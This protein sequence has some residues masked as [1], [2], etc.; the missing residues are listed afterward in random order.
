MR[1]L[2]T[3]GNG[4]LGSRV[5][6]QLLSTNAAVMVLS[7][8]STSLID[9]L[10]HIEF[11]HQTGSYVEHK[12]SIE[13]FAP[14]H[15]LHFAWEGGNRYEDVNSPLQ[16]S[17]NI[18]QGIELLTLVTKLPSRPQFLGIGSFSE[19]GTLRTKAREDQPDNPIS[20][21]G[22]AK[23]TFKTISQ[24][25]CA[26]AGLK[27]AW[28]RPCYVYGPND[29]STRLFPKVIRSLQSNL[30]V[31]LDS[32]NT[33][34]DYLHV[35]DFAQA[36]LQI[37][38]TNSTGILNVC[39]GEEYCLRTLLMFLKDKICSSG[40]I[41]FAEQKDRVLTSTYICGDNSRLRMIG[42]VPQISIYD[43]L[44]RLTEDST[45]MTIELKRDPLV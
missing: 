34:I 14:T 22:M 9:I 30:T 13:T 23:S 6:R 26:D 4:F 41:Q 25:M 36:V 20:F 12:Q 11:H 33:I 35:D 42:W 19:Y 18:P 39:S 43:G 5:V 10:D 40:D 27:W 2:I 21:Y 16:F 17:T 28:I 29:V 44:K 24:K 37:L 7:R 32:C 1:V 45:R 31:E 38:N 3:G 15:V 8:S